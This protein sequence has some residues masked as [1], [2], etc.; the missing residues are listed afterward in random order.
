MFRN[1]FLTI[2]LI[3]AAA[4]HPVG[5]F[6]QWGAAVKV[7]T[8]QAA[9]EPS[10]SSHGDTVTLTITATVDSKYH[11]YGMKQP[12]GTGPGPVA[13]TITLDEESLKILE[14]SGE[15]VEPKATIKFDKGFERDLSL[16]YGSPLKFTRAFKVKAS[17]PAGD[18]PIKGVLLSQA[19]TETSC[20]PP[21]ETPFEVALKVS[22]SPTATP[23]PES[24]MAPPPAATTTPPATPPAA[25]TTGAAQKIIAEKSFGT[26]LLGAF[27]FGLAALATPCVFPMIPITITFFTKQ[28]GN[29]RGK[30][31]K[32][33][34]LYVAS[35][36]AGF[37][38]IGFGISLLLL[39][40]GAGTSRA[41]FANWIAA[42][43]W[44]N[45]FFALL[46]IAFAL[47]LFEVFEFR[48]PQSLSS[49]L[50]QSAQGKNEV[51]G[52]I[53]KALVFV[54]ISFTCTAPLIGALIVQTITGGGWLRPLVGMAAFATGFA[55]PFFLLAL[56]PQWIASLPKA[57]AWMYS[58]KIVMGMLVIAAAFK[59][60]SNADLVWNKG[61]MI[62]TREVLLSVWVALSLVVAFYLFR[63]I[64]LP[65]DDPSA[66]SIGYSRM[67]M[68]TFAMMLA[69]YM[70]AGLFGGK[71]HAFIDSYLPPD[72]APTGGKGESLIVASRE[73]GG[74]EVS[75]GFSWFTEKDAAIAQAR[76]LGKNVFIDFTGYTCTNCRLM[77]KNMF[78]K[79]EVAALLNQYIR[80]KLVTDDRETGAK[81]QEYQA[82]TFGTV[83]LPFYAVITPDGEI[84]GTAEY[85]T[86]VAE[87]VSFLKSGLDTE[88]AKR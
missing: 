39:G 6:A 43:P 13:T 21:K 20:L 23:A 80:L 61:D 32:L 12:E 16:L 47:S 5:A 1:L 4:I 50:N 84:L 3:V 72:L 73:T 49:R 42:N 63:F 82:A 67:M 29:S 52:V 15:W 55:S 48:L 68:G 24:T 36:I 35:I 22:G 40:A 37:S 25:K 87:F 18:H 65:Q 27:L 77:E 19:C 70:G 30:S 9:M 85:T 78:P 10:E 62:L 53:F 31:V 75:A 26:F 69:L 33:A 14:P 51:T 86:D 44:V 76:K 8:V 79:P 64:R 28:S 41:G 59:F 2:L 66:Q 88:L 38:V 54:V 34:L 83:A 46:Y 17:A 81:W 11:L 60:L 45:L 56:A 7:V 58:T 71:I 57:G 74:T